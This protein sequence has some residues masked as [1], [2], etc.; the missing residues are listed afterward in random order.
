[1][2]QMVSKAQRDIWRR[3]RVLVAILGKVLALR[4][5]SRLYEQGTSTAG[6][7]TRWSAEYS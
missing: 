4:A 5:M 7:T 3:R 2:G 6:G 1:M